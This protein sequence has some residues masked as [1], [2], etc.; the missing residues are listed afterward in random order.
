MIKRIKK[1]VQNNISE[2]ENP[3]LLGFVSGF[4]PFIFYYSNNFFAINSWGHLLY[5]VSFFIGISTLLFLITNLLIKKFEFLKKHRTRIYFVLII[6]ITSVLLSYASTLLIKKKLLLGIL[7]IS[8][9]AS[10]KI[11]ENY[12]KIIVLIA[13]MSILPLIKVTLH[14]AENLTNNSWMKLPDTIE[15]VTFVK[16]PNVYMIQPD[17]YASLSEMKGVSYDFN[18]DLFPW[19]SKKQFTIY[20]DFRSNYPASLASNAS[21]FSMQQHKFGNTFFP[22]LEMPNAREA[23]YVN[24]PVLKIFKRNNYK[25]YFVVQDDY[26]Q[27]NRKESSFDYNNIRKE[28]ILFFSDGNHLKKDVFKDLKLAI[29]DQTEKPKFFFIEKLLPHH[30][31]F[32]GQKENRKERERLEYIEK[33]KEVNSWLKETISYIEQQD[34]NAIII[35]LADHGGWVGLESYNEMF[36]TKNEAQLRSIFGTLAAIKWNGYQ[37][38]GYDDNLQSNVNV[39]RVLFSVL[40]KNKEYLDNLEDDSSY[41]LLIDNFLYNSV[42]KVIS[43]NGEVVFK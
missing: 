23:I 30:I 41:N 39:F 10:F 16:K 13:L 3:L 4:Y 15:E 18:S 24:N 38:N 31:H 11:A 2:T 21:M 6:F 36:Q 17:G 8:V 43:D 5:F 14:I 27:Q 29:R 26:F 42:N 34:P 12:R 20:S 33:I 25:T 40:S 1:W 22:T 35:V 7:A 37:E 28:E 19:L 32:S 9:I